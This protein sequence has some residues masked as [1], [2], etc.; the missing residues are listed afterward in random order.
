MAASLKDKLARQASGETRLDFDPTGRDE[1]RLLPIRM[2]SI[3]PDP[4]QP[5]T[6]ISDVDELAQSIR[7]HG[8]LQ[9][10]V[11]EP[12]EDGRKYR[13]LAGHRRYKACQE[14]GLETIPC[15]VRTVQEHTR[16]ELQVIENIH[17]RDLSP[18][19]EARAL[20][21]L[22]DE[23]E[24]DQR[25]LADRLGKSLGSVNQT[26]RILSLSDEAL[27]SVQT[28]ERLSKSVLL[29]VAK[30]KDPQRQLSLIDK[31]KAGELRVRTARQ[32][33][34]RGGNEKPKPAV[35]NIVLDNATITIRFRK[36]TVSKGE[37]IATLQAA[38]DREKGTEPG[39]PN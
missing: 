25:G 39:G 10:I 23:F 28:S 33:R 6:D 20:K 17:R 34:G 9:P 1:Q 7:L 18:I 3:E 13:I 5:R 14:A 4:Q 37:R 35:H 29:E 38:L 31:A 27:A 16:L 12:I 24:L 21:R 22:Q 30:E 26:L 11:V 32:E 36:M 8:L 2:G 15:I 19:E